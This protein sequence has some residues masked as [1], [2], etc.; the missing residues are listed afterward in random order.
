MPKRR[1][2]QKG[3][4]NKK[5]AIP[6]LTAT[7]RGFNRTVG[8]WKRFQPLGPEKK[9]FAS[10]ANDIPVGANG[11]IQK[12]SLLAM[13]GGAGQNERI[14]RK[15]TVTNLSMYYT[16][17]FKSQDGAKNQIGCE[18]LRVIIYLD[19]QCN[20]AAALVTDI[21]ELDDI[22]SHNNLSNSGRFIILLDRW[23]D[24]HPICASGDGDGNNIWPENCASFEFHK[25]LNIP[26]YYRNE[27]ASLS[28]IQSNNLGFMTVTKNGSQI[29]LK[30]RF[31]IRFTDL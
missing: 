28:I 24:M 22:H 5:P 6:S 7:E 20:G 16:L 2:P 13:A 18:T 9:W 27:Q 10:L 17:V 8:N 15:I 29:N 3:K 21:L 1:L 11:V 14:G 30:S 31:R 4:Q 26:I 25:A 12:G 19:T 23:H